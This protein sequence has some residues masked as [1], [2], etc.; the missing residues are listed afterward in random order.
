LTGLRLAR[1]LNP[2][3]KV[4]RSATAQ[5]VVGNEPVRDVVPSMTGEQFFWGLSHCVTG[6]QH[7]VY[8]TPHALKRGVDLRC[9]FCAYDPVLWTTAKRSIIAESEQHLMWQL[10]KLGIDQL[11]CPQTKLDFWAAPFDFMMLNKRV[12]LQADGS[13]HFKDFYTTDV[14]QALKD[15][16]RFCV[17]AVKAHVSVVRVHQQQLT[18]MR[19]PAYLQTAIAEA[20]KHTCIVLSPGYN[21]VHFYDKGWFVSYAQLLADQLPGFRVLVGMCSNVVITRM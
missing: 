21:T 6:K 15:D 4:G 11:F 8:R 13:R 5:I 12:A 19:Y 20:E 17:A 1:C 16:M 10:A 2:E 3:V 14:E 9:P 7:Y 18:G